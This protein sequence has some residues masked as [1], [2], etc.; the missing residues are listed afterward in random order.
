M[1]R[2][3]VAYD[4]SPGAKAALERVDRLFPDAELCLVH[5]IGLPV[6]KLSEHAPGEPPRIPAP[7][8]LLAASERELQAVTRQGGHSPRC[9]AVVRLGNPVEV[10]FGAAADFQPDL[11]VV[12]THD[13]TAVQRLFLGSVA[14]RIVK[15]S[16]CP[17]LVVR[18]HPSKDPGAEPPHR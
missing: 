18:G 17:V 16:E 1:T 4:F 8:D 2:V 3:L 13:K 7:E 10:I 6:D 14:E 15:R 11:I 12:G 9:Q 5:A